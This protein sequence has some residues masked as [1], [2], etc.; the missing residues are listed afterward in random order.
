MHMLTRTTVTLERQSNLASPQTVSSI[1]VF[2]ILATVWYVQEEGSDYVREQVS[3]SASQVELSIWVLK[4]LSHKYVHLRTAW[5]GKRVSVKVKGRREDSRVCGCGYFCISADLKHTY[6]FPLE[7]IGPF[8]FASTSSC[9]RGALSMEAA[10]GMKMETTSPHR[11]GLYCYGCVKHDTLHA[12]QCPAWIKCGI[13]HISAWAVTNRN[14]DEG[15][16][17]L[18]HFLVPI[19]GS[20]NS[21]NYFHL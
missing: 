19:L 6:C 17:T 10:S 1:F 18:A 12:G 9:S 3:P 16:Q 8:V 7:K 2:G 21:P 4:E 20:V 13:L 11:F 14:A 5:K 15:Y